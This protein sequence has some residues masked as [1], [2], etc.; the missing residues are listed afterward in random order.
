MEAN[1]RGIKALAEGTG[2]AEALAP[3]GLGAD[4]G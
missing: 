4:A 3:D 1:L 2:E